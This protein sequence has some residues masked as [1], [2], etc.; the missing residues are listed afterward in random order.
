MTSY[1]STTW[2]IVHLE[3]AFVVGSIRVKVSTRITHQTRIQESPLYSYNRRI[4]LCFRI[5]V[6]SNL[7]IRTNAKGYVSLLY[8]GTTAL[9]VYLVRASTIFKEAYVKCLAARY[10]GGP[11]AASEDHNNR[12]LVLIQCWRAV[13]QQKN[14][15]YEV[16]IYGGLRRRLAGRYSRGPSATSEDRNYMIIVL[17]HCCRAEKTRFLSQPRFC[18]RYERS[19]FRNFQ[20]LKS[21]S[22]LSADTVIESWRA[23]FKILKNWKVW[24]SYRQT[25]ISPIWIIACMVIDSSREAGGGGCSVDLGVLMVCL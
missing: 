25:R 23:H 5:N 15:S 11:S 19:E 17:M 20:N 16:N 22:F 2:V 10:S 18:Q 13:V 14:T 8:C 1:S 3:R 6:K 21:S 9:S 7:R 12:I 4:L 24:V